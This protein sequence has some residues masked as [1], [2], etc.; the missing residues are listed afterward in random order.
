MDIPRAPRRI[1]V[2]KPSSLGDVV[3]GLAFLAA[4]RRCYPDA[5]IDWVI[6][7]G[8]DG[9]LEGHP[10]I[11]KLWVIDKDRWKRPL[12]LGSTIAELRALHSGM[13]E[14]N[15]DIAVD[16]QGLFRSGL[17]AWLS[18]SKVRVGI[19]GSREGSG[20][21]YTHIAPADPALHAVDRCLAAARYIGCADGPVEFPVL[22]S[23]Y[24]L[25]DGDYAVIVPGARWQTKRW[26]P[27][28]FGELASMLPIRSYVV[29]SSEDTWL[30]DK[31]VGHS[32]GHA[33]S[34]AGKTNLKQLATVLKGARFV[35]TNDT[36]TMHIA[37]GLGVP[38][39]A[40]FGPTDPA[41]TGPYGPIHTVLYGDLQCSPCRKKHHCPGAACMNTI[42]V[43]DVRAALAGRL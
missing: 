11:S 8:I 3:H 1:L 15:Y 4:I 42:T 32:G 24:P 26:A 6:A 39:V 27:E 41:K 14:R 20:M 10:M 2:I 12:S 36:G 9:L 30:A 23:P 25:P 35:I 37:A 28:R 18:G 34:L 38:V 7:R 33:E 16:L 13:R 29:G 5:E 21:F 17:I 43:D 19:E 22:S 40:I 31:V